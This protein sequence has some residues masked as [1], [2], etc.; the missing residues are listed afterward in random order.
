MDYDV[1]Y[2]PE[3]FA[4]PSFNGSPTSTTA[5]DIS[6]EFSA[7]CL[8]VSAAVCVDYVSSSQEGGRND[9]K[10]LLRR[11]L[12]RIAQSQQ[13]FEL[14]KKQS[15]VS[16]K[17]A[18][19]TMRCIL[20]IGEDS[21]AFQTCNDGLS[22]ALIKLHLNDISASDEEFPTLRH[23]KVSMTLAQQKSMTHTDRVLTKLA[24]EMIRATQ[25]CVVDLG[26][27]C[28]LSLGDLQR[29]IIS[30]ASSV[31]EAI[32]VFQEIDDIVKKGGKE[33]SDK[34]YSADEFSWFAIESH[35]RGTQLLMIGDDD[36]AKTFVT[37][38]LNFVKFS[39]KE[40]QS[41]EQQMMQSFTACVQKRHSTTFF[42]EF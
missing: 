5:S 25:K 35:N 16:T 26:G 32:G 4:V 14:N 13:E 12:H 2:E 11:S 6:S 36:N 38:A 30:T 39:N 42:W 23:V 9:R 20:E 3:K 7:Q 22:A 1:K 41:Y 21:F 40:T 15:K 24:I 34:L 17:I 27:G 19:L 37:F 18:T 8:L 29:K 31:D 33:G 10:S 28:L